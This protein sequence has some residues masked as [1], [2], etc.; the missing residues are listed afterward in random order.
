MA[1]HG[2]SLSKQRA[3]IF[4]NLAVPPVHKTAALK[5]YRE[6]RRPQQREVEAWHADHLARN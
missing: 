5:K 3:V 2:P 4:L 1:D 6:V